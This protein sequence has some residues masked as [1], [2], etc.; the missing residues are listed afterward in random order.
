MRWVIVPIFVSA[1]SGSGLNPDLGGDTDDTDSTEVTNISPAMGFVEPDGNYDYSITVYTI[2]WNA[3]DP[4]SDATIALYYGSETEAQTL[5]VEGLFEGTDN[6]YEWD[7]SQVSNGDWYIH[8]VIEDEKSSVTAVSP[9]AINVAHIIDEEPTFSFV[10]PDGVDDE[11]D[12]SFDIVWTDSDSDSEAAISLF[13]DDDNT[14]ADGTL[15]EMGILED[16]STDLF[17]WDTSSLTNGDYYIYSIISDGNTSVTTYANGPVTVYHNQLPNLTIIEPDGNDDEGRDEYVITWVDED[18]NDDAEISLYYDVDDTGEDGTLIVDSI[19]EDD[20]ADSYTWDTSAILE[21]DYWIYGI[22][23]DTRVTVTSYSAGSVFITHNPCMTTSTISVDIET[24]SVAFDVY[25]DGSTVDS[26]NT[27]DDDEA[28]LVLYNTATGLSSN[29]PSMW[30]DASDTANYPHI[31]SLIAGYY[32]IY[33]EKVNAGDNWP[34]NTNYPLMTDVDLTADTMVTVDIDTIDVTFDLTLAGVAV[35]SVNTWSD[36]KGTLWFHDPVEDDSFEL[37]GIWDDNLQT[38]TIPYTQRVLPGT[39]DVYYKSVEEGTNW[40]INNKALIATNEDFGY[41]RSVTY[42]VEVVNI[43]LDVTLGGQSITSA[44]T[45]SSDR[46]SI[47]LVDT[48]SGDKIDPGTLWDSSGGH[49]LTPFNWSI[50]PS[51]FDVYYEVEASGG[52]N[53]PVN[54][55]HIVEDDLD[56]TASG[57]H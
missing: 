21:G 34:G 20:V 27:A 57:S 47:Y 12:A 55:D 50:F 23:D 18:D 31:Q 9:G 25:L 32:D 6:S 36:D 26:T 46:G 56:L 43:S 37:D 53:W 1:C 30:D 29:L 44:N 4:D 51:T 10:E 28:K 13:W 33:Y 15:I 41:S 5:I 40:P 49:A 14:G 38:Q 52:T 17:S 2:L 45:S 22:I 7:V 16:D 19:S 3:T 48:T 39:F 8:G 42:D 35:S 11:G 24:V 54:N